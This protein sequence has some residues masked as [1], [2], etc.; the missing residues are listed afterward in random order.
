MSS[1]TTSKA[2]SCKKKSTIWL[3]LQ[4]I[5]DCEFYMRNKHKS[6]QKVSQSNIVEKF[7]PSECNMWCEVS[8]NFEFFTDVEHLKAHVLS[9]PS[10]LL[11][12]IGSVLPRQW[13][14]FLFPPQVFCPT[15]AR[16]V[17]VRVCEG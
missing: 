17:C 10:L 8:S 16:H 3:V 15:L 7:N 4:L 1:F 2:G 11:D 6:F 5:S 13:S 14:P 9:A 12:L